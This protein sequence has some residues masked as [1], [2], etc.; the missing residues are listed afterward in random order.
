MALLLKTKTRVLMAM[1]KD[2]K[3]RGLSF[4]TY[5]EVVTAPEMIELIRGVD[6]TANPAEIV[7]GLP[8]IP[9]VD[10][11]RFGLPPIEAL[12]TDLSL[13]VPVLAAA[14]GAARAG[15][16]RPAADLLER[17][18]G[19]WAMR[20][21]AVHALGEAAA[22]DARWLG[23]WRAAA[24]ENRHLAA[25]DAHGLL[26]LAWKL[27]GSAQ[28]DQTA[29]AQHEAFYS[30]LER[31]EAAAHHASRLAPED[32]TPWFTLVTLARG[33]GY[34]AETFASVWRELQA[35]DPLHR[36]GHE[37]AAMYLSP[38]DGPGSYD[39]L[40]AF[41]ERAAAASPSLAFLVLQAAVDYEDRD[42]AIWRDARVLHALETVLHRLSTPAGASGVFAN[43]DRH[44][45]A[46]ALVS[47]GRG[48]AAIPLFAQLGTD[49]SARP[50][51]DY[52][53][54]AIAVFDSFRRRACAAA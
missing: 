19:D 53:D 35:R 33:R 34:D 37:F 16:W 54:A 36:A 24:G 2:A 21:A 29:A 20:A 18:Y 4:A 6:P 45:A 42:E 15:D 50:W 1:R 52:N 12:S 26:W 14:V 3:H 48:A 43:G 49:V 30:T 40:F 41:A 9:A 11:T 44:W 32:P 47:A 31:S 27:R 13:P 38:E 7:P 10:V 17:S 28:P 46:Y 23:A 51:Q 39:P 5:M 8:D 22:D 25:V